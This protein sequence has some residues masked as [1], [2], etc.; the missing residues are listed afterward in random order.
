MKSV[1]KSIWQISK[2]LLTHFLIIFAYTIGAGFY[3]GV[4]MGLS[5]KT[6]DIEAGVQ[7]FLAPQTAIAVIIA[8]L[9]AFL[10]YQRSLKKKGLNIFRVCRFNAIHKGQVLASIT[11]G[12]SILFLSLLVL[13]LV[14]YLLPDSYGAHVSNMESIMVASPLIVILSVGVAAPLIEEVMFRGL[15]LRELEKKTSIMMA[16]FVQAAIFGIYHMNIAHSIM[17]TLVGVFLG[18]SLYWTGSIWAPMLIHLVNNLLSVA[19]E[20]SGFS[21][22]LEANPFAF[23]AIQGGMAFIILP[24]SVFVLYRSRTVWIA[25][26]DHNEEVLASDLEPEVELAKSV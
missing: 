20:L 18:L 23:R 4:V 8:A 16:I 14:S 21:V 12:A 10:I 15:V 24:L 5:G 9:V 13:E 6:D 19:L 1:I 2:I 3:Y 22:Y 25:G 17:A 7:A 26:E 11:M